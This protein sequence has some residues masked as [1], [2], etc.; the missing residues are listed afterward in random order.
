MFFSTP[1][2][3][4]VGFLPAIPASPGGRLDKKKR[5]DN[6]VFNPIIIPTP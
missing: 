1:D 4:N 6:G 3:S 2:Q 5:D